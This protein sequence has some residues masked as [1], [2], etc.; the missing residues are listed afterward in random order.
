MRAPDGNEIVDVRGKTGVPGE[1]LFDIHILDY[2]HSLATVANVA[3]KGLDP[4]SLTWTLFPDPNI[5]EQ[6][7]TIVASYTQLDDLDKLYDY[8]KYWNCLLYTSPSPR[9]GATSRM[10][11][12]A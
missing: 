8:A 7:P 1:D 11:S 4:L 6:N 10:P 9:D 2:S 5:S 12:S 3:M